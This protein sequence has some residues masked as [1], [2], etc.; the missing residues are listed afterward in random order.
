M[1]IN[2]LSK[3]FGKKVVTTPLEEFIG[4]ITLEQPRAS[5]HAVN[6]ESLR[7]PAALS[8]LALY[9]AHRFSNG[10]R[11]M[12]TKLDS[13]TNDSFPYDAVA[14]EAAAYC[15]Y[16]LMRD[17]L[18]SDDEDETSDESYFE[19][20]KDSANM[21]SSLLAG[22]I[23]FDLPNDL[24]MNRS[25]A[26][27]FEEKCKSVR[28]E[29]KFAQFLISSIQSR[30]PLAKTTVGIESRLPLQLAVASYIPIFKSNSLA[31]FKK[32]ARGLFLAGQE[33]AL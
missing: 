10:L 9:L 24:L 1:V 16:W 19:C 13:Q 30:S 2:I 18:N 26:Y 3:L 7:L 5:Y 15:Y 12:L 4:S 27:S 33:G 31:E 32:T 29:E 20:L 23:S 8:T 21:T 22:K 14:F 17:M 11:E 25:I 6:D 28:S